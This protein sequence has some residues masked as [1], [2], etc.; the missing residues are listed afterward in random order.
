MTTQ[1]KHCQQLVG[2]EEIQNHPMSEIHVFGYFGCALSLQSSLVYATYYACCI[3]AWG[4]FKKIQDRSKKWDPEP[5]IWASHAFLNSEYLCMC[6]YH[7]FKND[8]FLS[9]SERLNDS[10]FRKHAF[11]S[12]WWKKNIEQFIMNTLNDHDHSSQ[13]HHVNR[14]P[15]VETC[16]EE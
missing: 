12:I 14:A 2:N 15:V 9:S 16:H 6:G 5:L 10:A 1:G 4:G 3:C 13:N 11:I 8:N 7:H